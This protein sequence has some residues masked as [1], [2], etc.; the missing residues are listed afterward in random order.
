MDPIADMLTRIRNA[1]RA[2]KEVVEVPTSK[3]K[4]EI[5]R[6]LKEE[7]FVSHYRTFENGK[8]GLLKI[9][10]RYTNEKEPVL[11][12]IERVSKSSRRVYRGWQEIGKPSEGF[13]ETRSM[14]ANTGSF[15]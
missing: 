3:L 4:R 2:N 9:L 15:S 13:S 6:V 7:G 11:A 8:Q 1:V 10:L 14:P 5:A 12:G